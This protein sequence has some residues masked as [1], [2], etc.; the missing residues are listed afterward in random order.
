MLFMKHV[1]ENSWHISFISMCIIPSTIFNWKFHVSISKTSWGIYMSYISCC[2]NFV[3][4]G[5]S[6]FA[7]HLV[8]HILDLDYLDFYKHMISHIRLNVSNIF[9]PNTVL[10]FKQ[11]IQTWLYF[12]IRNWGTFYQIWAYLRLYI[13]PLSNCY[14]TL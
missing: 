10:I 9:I 8:Q 4:I 5:I 3:W 7:W 11:C 13:L 2:A 6:V 14:F 12:I 1:L